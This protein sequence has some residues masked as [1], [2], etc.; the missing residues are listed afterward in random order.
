M[1]IFDFNIYVGAPNLIIRLTIRPLRL[2]GAAKSARLANLVVEGHFPL[3]HAA[4]KRFAFLT[5]L[6]Y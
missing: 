2:F 3:E 5:D 4:N 6:S 1:L